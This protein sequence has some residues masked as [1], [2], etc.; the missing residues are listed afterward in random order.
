MGSDGAKTTWLPLESNPDVITEYL[1][2]LGL[3]DEQFQCVD[4]YG[5]DAELLQMV[6]SGVVAVLLL[7]PIS[8]ASEAFRRLERE[9]AQAIV[10]PKIWFTKQTVPNAC[11]TVG[12]LH[13][14]YNNLAHFKLRTDEFLIN[15]YNRTK[16]QTPSER[17]VSL[18]D[19]ETIRITHREA[20]AQGSS[21]VPEDLNNVDLHFIAFVCVN[22]RL[23]ELD[24]R[25]DR[26]TDH[27]ATT[28]E[29][30]LY[31][32]VGVVKQFVDRDPGNVNFSMLAIVANNVS[33]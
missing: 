26:P 23:I 32:A 4:I 29:N 33:D 24:G 3:S 18:S 27:G 14:V 30:L 6:P 16:N 5:T 28:A 17:A 10:D 21:A 20:A 19:D 13:T 11:G 22:N 8:E 7:F 12:L 15:F 25:K 2:K 9:K 31:N 1:D